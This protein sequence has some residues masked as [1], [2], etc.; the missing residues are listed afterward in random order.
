MYLEDFLLIS[1]YAKESL[2][3]DSPR[4]RKHKLEFLLRHKIGV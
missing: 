4:I 1:S 3:E 2:D